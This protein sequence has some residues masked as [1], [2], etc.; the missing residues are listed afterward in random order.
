M[1]K[2]IFKYI[3]LTILMYPICLLLTFLD[4]VSFNNIWLVTLLLLILI[5]SILC[6][7]EI[8]QKKR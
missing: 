6:I 1:C 4:N 2:T 8:K 3:G 5:N 7:H